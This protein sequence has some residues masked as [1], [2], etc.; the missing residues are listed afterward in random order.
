M[1]VPRTPEDWRGSPPRKMRLPWSQTP[2]D[3]G[4][5]YLPMYP[6]EFAPA[7]GMERPERGRSPVRAPVVMR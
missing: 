5:P 3:V 4:G 2:K 7:A 6:P 1:R